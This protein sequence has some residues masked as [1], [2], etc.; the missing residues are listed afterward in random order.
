M[1][2]PNRRVTVWSRSRA[3]MWLAER[4]YPLHFVVNGLGMPDAEGKYMFHAGRYWAW[5]P[6]GIDPNVEKLGL[7][8]ANKKETQL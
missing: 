8:P 2:N 3:G 5:I 6:A 7:E 4:S 1:E